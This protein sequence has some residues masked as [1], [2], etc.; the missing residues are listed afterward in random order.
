MNKKRLTTV[1]ILALIGLAIY[2]SRDVS[3]STD[4]VTKTNYLMGTIVN[5]TVYDNSD[6]SIFTGAFDLIADIESK[7]SLNIDGS[8][9]DEI[10]KS[11]GVSPVKVSSDTF[12]VIEK[13]IYYSELSGGKF[14]I[15]SG[16]LVKLWDI[17]GENARV[18]SPEE[19]ERELPLID[20][21]NIILDKQNSTV[22]LSNPQM[23]LDLGGI[24][25]GY[26]ADKVAEYL[27]SKGV[28]KAIVDIGGNLF[29]L[30]TSTENSPWNIGIK[31][32]FSESRNE[33]IGSIQTV[34]SSIVTSGVYE[35]FL[36]SDGIRYHHILDPDTGYPSENELMGVTISCKSSIDAD[37]LS[38]SVFLL[39]L[40]DGMKLVESLDGVEAIFVTK[41]KEVYLSSGAKELFEIKDKD[42]RVVK[43]SF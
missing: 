14:D 23:M 10:N 34:D 28:K 40:T 2:R 20:Y 30:G 12:D 33:Y 18:P 43:K 16:G 21:R 22:M 36:E 41:S 8:E 17:G 3:K 38:T 37:G 26:A 7:M 42:F 15:S 6:D 35:R 25:K 32:P 39:G 1:L 19:I 24:A 27:K 5:L 13:S 31:N 11:A 9:V 29:L 4:P